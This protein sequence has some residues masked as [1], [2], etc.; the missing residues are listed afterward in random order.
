MHVQ[1]WMLQ[2]LSNLCQGISLRV[3]NCKAD[4]ISPVAQACCCPSMLWQPSCGRGWAMQAANTHWCTADA[5]KRSV[6][7]STEPDLMSVVHT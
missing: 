6:T 2:H 7:C 5:D 1:A 4:M 3:P